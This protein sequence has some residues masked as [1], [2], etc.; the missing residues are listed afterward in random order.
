M[1]TLSH[2]LDNIIQ[3]DSIY[4]LQKGVQLLVSSSGQSLS[5]DFL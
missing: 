2:Y 4:S 5:A 3:G 1:T